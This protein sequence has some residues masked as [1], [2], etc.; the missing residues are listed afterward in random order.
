MREVFYGL[1]V[2]GLQ[3]DALQEIEDTGVFAV[4]LTLVD[5]GFSSSFSHTFDAAQTKADVAFAVDGK[6]EFG[7]VDIGLQ[8]AQS[9]RFTLVHEFGDFFDVVLMDGEVSSHELGR[10][11]RFEVTR[12]VRYP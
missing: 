1:A 5:D 3:V 7:L 2:T 9:Q 8:H 4:L 11:V 6:R 10:V 12:L